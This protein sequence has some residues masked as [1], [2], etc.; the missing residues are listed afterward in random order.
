MVGD[1]RSVV[2]AAALMRA[3]ASRVFYPEEHD[4]K[5]RNQ[6]ALHTIVNNIIT[7][8]KAS[9]W[10]YGATFIALSCVVVQAKPGELGG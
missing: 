7:A 9:V 5:E 3:A 10:C 2:D 1:T 6:R 8:M 4:L